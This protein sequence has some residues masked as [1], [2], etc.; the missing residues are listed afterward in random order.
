[1]LVT[2]LDIKYI[3]KAIDY[4]ENVQGYTAVIIKEKKFCETYVIDAMYGA[5]DEWYRLEVNVKFG[6]EPSIV[7][8]E[9]M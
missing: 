5:T 3:N 2:R 9:K 4:V 8:S 7:T 6:D 1:M